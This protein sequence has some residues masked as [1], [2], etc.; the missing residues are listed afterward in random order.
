MPRFFGILIL[1]VISCG[2]ATAGGVERDGIHPA[3]R[4][5][6][7]NWQQ[8]IQREGWSQ[9]QVESILGQFRS[10]VSYRMEIR[11]HWDT[12]KEFMR[13]RFSGDC[14]DI[15]VF[16]MGALKRMNYPYRVR[17]L[18]VRTLFE[19]HALLRLE[20]PDGGWRVY[21]VAASAV[22]AVEPGR[23]TPVVE[24]DETTVVWHSPK[25]SSVGKRK[26]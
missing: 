9:G 6:I 20:L 12:P 11:D 13:N 16:M 15:V 10:L 7:R 2:C 25:G 26:Y 17:I 14:E 1:F 8:R 23:L 3:Y 18:V 21:D 24:F 22:R 19:D 5:K 4:E